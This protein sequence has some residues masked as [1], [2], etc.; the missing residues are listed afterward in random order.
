MAVEE[1][2]V[3]V[4][5]VLPGE[6][7]AVA[8]VEVAVV[9]VSEASRISHVIP[10]LDDNESKPSSCVSLYRKET[11]KGGYREISFLRNVCRVRTN[12]V[13]KRVFS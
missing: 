9:S 13:A 8:V 3:E 11:I 7:E 4:D 10:K 5:I 6:D 1:V 2:A 12:D